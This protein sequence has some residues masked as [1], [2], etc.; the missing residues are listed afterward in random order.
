MGWKVIILKLFPKRA[1]KVIS[2]KRREL[3]GMKKRH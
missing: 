3:E 2:A 1:S